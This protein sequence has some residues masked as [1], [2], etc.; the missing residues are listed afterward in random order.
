MNVFGLL[1][2]VHEVCG[3]PC[4]G[5]TGYGNGDVHETEENDQLQHRHEM[6]CCCSRTSDQGRRST[7]CFVC[8]FRPEGARA[9]RL[10]EW[11]MSLG[12]ATQVRNQASSRLLPNSGRRLAPLAPDA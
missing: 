12:E 11:Q 4:I 1:G 2:P 10:K 6:I 3:T 8:S 5:T 9:T 7:M